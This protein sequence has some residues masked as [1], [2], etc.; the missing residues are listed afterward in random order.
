MPRYFFH[1]RNTI[2]S[3]DE[4]GQELPDA[5]AARD[6]A[7]DCAREL[8]CADIKRGWLNLDHHIVVADDSG[9]SLFSLTFR[10]AFEI[11]TNADEA[12]APPAPRPVPD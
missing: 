6:H 3:D 1:L 8:V 7:L 9:A 10:E 4:E 12:P 5:A 11:R 2:H